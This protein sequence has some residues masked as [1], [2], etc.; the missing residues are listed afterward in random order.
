MQL[1]KRDKEILCFINESGF[2]VMPQIQKEFQLKFPRSYQIMKRLVSSGYVIHDQIFKK[3]H[4]F[5]YLTRKGAKNTSLPPLPNI[6]LG[7]YQHQIIL[8][9]IRQNYAP[10][11]QTQS[12]LA[13]VISNNKNFITVLANLVISLM[14]Y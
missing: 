7:G 2:C 10:N 6:S 5:Y 8:T 14:E 4:G 13:N 11:I 3:Q 9:D 12:G 1:T